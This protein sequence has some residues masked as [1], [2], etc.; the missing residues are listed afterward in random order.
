MI[1]ENTVLQ[2]VLEIK[3]DKTKDESLHYF[4]RYV[5][6]ID[7]MMYEEKLSHHLKDR[8]KSI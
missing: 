7:K 4:L 5:E 1:I 3:T 6:A 8:R 2:K